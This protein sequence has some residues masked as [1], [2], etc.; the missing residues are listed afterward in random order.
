MRPASAGW[1]DAGTIGGGPTRHRGRSNAAEADAGFLPDQPD[2]VDGELVSRQH[3]KVLGK[4]HF[5]HQEPGTAIRQDVLKLRPARGHV[6]R[7]RDRAEPCTT[8]RDFEKLDTVRA[9]QGDAVTRLDAGRVQR[10]GKARRSVPGVG[11]GPGALA[12]ADERLCGKALGLACEHAGQ[13]P[14][15]RRKR[16]RPVR[17]QLLSRRHCHS[18]LPPR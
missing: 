2:G 4:G 18:T 15:G 10:S 13:R 1:I 14:L 16:F 7:H 11:V 17:S 12:S 3:R 6:D 9:D 8:E 5:H